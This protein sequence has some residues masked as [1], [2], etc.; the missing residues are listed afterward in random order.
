VI[1]T[2]KEKKD[3]IFT[4]LCNHKKVSV[5]GV[6]NITSFC[7]EFIKKSLNE[8]IEEGFATKGKY[9]GYWKVKPMHKQSKL[10]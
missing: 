8:F 2:E 10:F 1:K 5:D 6:K 9:A 3:E 4:I 7:S